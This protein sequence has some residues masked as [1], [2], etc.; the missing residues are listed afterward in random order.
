MNSPAKRVVGVSPRHI[1][2]KSNSCWL[3][4]DLGESVSI[5]DSAYGVPE[6]D[7]AGQVANGCSSAGAAAPITE[8]G[9]TASVSSNQTY[10][11]NCAG[12]TA[13]K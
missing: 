1:V 4:A 7:D 12:S 9:S 10:S 13:W 8:S 6:V 5:H 3:T 2:G 11:S